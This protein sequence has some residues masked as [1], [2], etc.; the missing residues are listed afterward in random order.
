M[1]FALLLYGFHKT[2]KKPRTK[3]AKKAGTKTGKKAGTKTGKKAK[4]EETAEDNVVKEA[5]VKAV[6]IVEDNDISCEVADMFLRLQNNLRNTF[7]EDV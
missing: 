6:E 5:E 4:A 2:V 1:I 3:A 7:E